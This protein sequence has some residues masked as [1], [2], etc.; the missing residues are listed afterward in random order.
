MSYDSGVLA[1]SDPGDVIM[2]YVVFS[3][4]HSNL[5]ALRAFEKSIKNVPHDKRV[6]LGDIVGYGADPN[7]VTQWIRKNCQIVLGGNHDFAV[8]GKTDTSYFNSYA[9]E[10]CVWTRKKLE[11]PNLEFLRLLGT[12][13]VED[14]ITWVHSSPFQPEKWHY[15]TSNSDGDVNFKN[16][17]TQVCFVGHSHIPLI[18]EQDPEGKVRAFLRTEYRL[19]PTHRYIFNVGSLGQP[20]DRNPDSSFVTYESEEGIIRFNRFPYDLA[21]TQRKILREGLPSYLAERLKIGR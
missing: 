1:N 3:D 4:I 21:S 20:R 14:G 2:V 5:E 10:A 8:A 7:S 19:K 11:S 9:L 17:Y 12:K 18:L 15:I 13:L 16:F 6:C